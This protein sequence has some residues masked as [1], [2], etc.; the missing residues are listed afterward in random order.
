MSECWLEK[1]EDR[2]AF[3]WI[4]TAMKRLIN[5]HK[6]HEK[7]QK[8]KYRGNRRQRFF[9]F[10]MKGR[11]NRCGAFLALRIEHQLKVSSVEILN[12][13]PCE[14]VTIIDQQNSKHDVMKFLTVQLIST[15]IS[16]A[17]LTKDCRI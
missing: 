2:P 13:V 16:A 17:K 14:I 11:I 6:V 9:F 7:A 15:N 12:K 8:N 5:D 3:R 4:C 1:P 10:Y